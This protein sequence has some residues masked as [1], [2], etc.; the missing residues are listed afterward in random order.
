VTHPADTLVYDA[1]KIAAR[2]A[3]GRFDYNSQLG[4]PESGLLDILRRWLSR[5]LRAF[6]DSET[7][8]SVTV[9][10]LIAFFVL[11]VGLILFFIYRK[12]PELFL[13]EK[14]KPL[15]HEVEEENIYRIDFEK[16]LAAALAANDFRLAVRMLYLQTLRLAADRQWIDWQIYKTPTEYA[17]ELK[18]AGLKATFRDFTNR[19]LQVRYGNFRATRELF[20]SM[21]RLQDEL[22]KGG[23]RETDW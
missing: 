6:F 23:R 11:A 2:Q 21:C 10:L 13:R 4:A 20:D 8:E 16:E 22:G 12:R 18:P 3:D 7:A 19:F 9:W 5:C 14:R 15:S 17:R 1:A